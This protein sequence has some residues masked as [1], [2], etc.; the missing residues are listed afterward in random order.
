MLP[1]HEDV[2]DVGAQLA[3]QAGVVGDHQDAEPGPIGRG[4][5]LGLDASGAGP[6]RVEVE[7][8]VELVEDGD[9]GFE[10]G[11]LQRLVAL[12]LA[13]GQVDVERP[14]QQGLVEADPVGLLE[15]SCLQPVGPSAPGGEG[16]VE[17]V[18]EGDARDLR[19]VLQHEVQ[20]GGG[21]LHVGRPS[22]STPSRVTVPS[23]T[24]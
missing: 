4:L 15:Q 9:A 13:T 5:G 8:G 2:H 3:Q 23:S 20:A 16:L 18:V 19:R 12:L 22:M 7:P 21:A 10:H 6:Q 17:H 24:S 1:A 11:Q 14:V